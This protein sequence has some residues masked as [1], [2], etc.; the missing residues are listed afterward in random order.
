MWIPRNSRY[1]RAQSAI[2]KGSFGLRTE[3]RNTPPYL[4]D[5]DFGN[6]EIQF[7]NAAYR[8][9]TTII[10]APG[11]LAL[12]LPAAVFAGRRRR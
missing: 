10:P 9:E 6:Y 5:F 7:V 11:V 3:S 1:S 12:G 4:Y 8:L 2:K